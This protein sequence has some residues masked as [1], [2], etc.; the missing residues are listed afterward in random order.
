[1]YKQNLE[2]RISADSSAYGIGGVLE[3]KQP[4]GD[5][6]PVYFC[7]KTLTETQC[8]YAQIE[9]ECLAILYVCERLQQFLI[10]QHFTICTDH[11]P[12]LQILK[13]KHLND[14]SVRLQRMRMRLMQ[15]NYDIKFLPGKEFYTPDALSRAPLSISEADSDVLFENCDTLYIQMLINESTKI[16]SHDRE[17]ILKEQEKDVTVK[18]VKKYV[19]HGWPNKEKLTNLSSAFYK[20]RSA[21]N[22]IE[23]ICFEDRIVIPTNM[24]KRTLNEIHLGHQGLNRSKRR[25]RMAV[26]WPGMNSQ[27]EDIVNQCEI[28]LKHKISQVEP[29]LQPQI[30]CLPWE[31]VAVDL[32]EHKNVTYW[33]FKIVSVNIPKW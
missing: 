25:A 30:P 1:M 8:R 13:T 6:K 19:K 26:W 22:I 18:E 27:I 17:E 16:I 9:K 32:C 5:W 28:C 33:K 20:Y 24:R 2:T 12:L 31:A 10:G 7:S 15:F 29:L 11:K 14:L 3:Q 23:G 21:L 4:T